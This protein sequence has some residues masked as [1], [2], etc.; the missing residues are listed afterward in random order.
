MGWQP[1]SDR[2]RTGVQSL[3]FPGEATP[4]SVAQFT[5]V[6]F[7]ADTFRVKETHPNHQEGRI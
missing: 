7:R 6:I 4:N 5:R 2:D 3:E 1:G